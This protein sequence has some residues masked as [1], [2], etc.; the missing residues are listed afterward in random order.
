M[1]IHPV[2]IRR[3]RLAEKLDRLFVVPVLERSDAVVHD[4]ILRE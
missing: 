1:R 3:D 2:R 4:G